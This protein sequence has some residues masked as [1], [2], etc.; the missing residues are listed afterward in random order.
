MS[1]DQKAIATQSFLKYGDSNLSTEPMPTIKVSSI[2]FTA[3][4][5][6]SLND[7]DL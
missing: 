1:N 7:I 5:H 3:S 4:A 6:R 2:A